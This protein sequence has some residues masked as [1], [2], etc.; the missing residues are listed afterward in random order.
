MRTY[1]TIQVGDGTTFSRT[2]T[3]DDVRAFADVSGDHNPI[4]LDAA[5]AAETPFGRP[6]VHGVFLLAVLSKVLAHDYPGAGSVAVSLSC[7]FL[8]PVPVGSEVTVEV[9]V[10]EKIERFGHIRVKAWIYGEGRKMA[11]AGEA[12]LVPPRTAA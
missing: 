2:I 9:R 1:D 4:H 3:A 5:A 7:K 12:V 11:A 6:I 8:R 10:E